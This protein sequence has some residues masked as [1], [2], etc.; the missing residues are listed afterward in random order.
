MANSLVMDK[1]FISFRFKDAFDPAMFYSKYRPVMLRTKHEISN[2][3]RNLFHDTG[4][5]GVPLGL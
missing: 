3:S 1:V 5:V 4:I 2:V